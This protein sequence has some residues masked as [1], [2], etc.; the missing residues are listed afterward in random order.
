MK[1]LAF[2]LDDE[3]NWPPV[4]VEHLWCEEIDGMFELRSIPLFVKKLAVGDR[5]RAEPDPVNACIF[6]FSTVVNGGHSLVRI[7]DSEDIDSSLFKREIQALGC[8]MSTWD[9]YGMSAFDVPVGIDI[10]AINELVDRIQDSG[11]PIS[12][13]VWRH[14][15][16]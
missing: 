13:P 8:N 4:L 11:L 15:P 2:A 6:E 12:F 14:D 16:D 1:Q 5:F 10:H 9:A 3:G 7:M